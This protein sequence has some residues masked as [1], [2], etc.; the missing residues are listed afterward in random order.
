MAENLFVR[1]GGNGGSKVCDIVGSYLLSQLTHLSIKFG[2]NRDTALFVRTKQSHYPPEQVIEEW[3]THLRQAPNYG[4]CNAILTNFLEVIAQEAWH[5]VEY[6]HVNSNNPRHVTK[7]TVAEVNHQLSALC[8]DGFD[9]GGFKR[10]GFPVIGHQL[11]QLFKR[12]TVQCS[13]WFASTPSTTT[14]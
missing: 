5:P 1:M 3:R 9:E 2:L 14:S 13:T 4:L 6:L 7:N 11:H 12:H 10:A 8:I